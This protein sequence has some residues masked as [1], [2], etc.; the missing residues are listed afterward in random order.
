MELIVH[1]EL[2]AWR[3]TSIEESGVHIDLLLYRDQRHLWFTECGMLSRCDHCA[4][5]STTG[6]TASAT[7]VKATPMTRRL[8][9][10]SLRWSDRAQE[11]GKGILEAGRSSAPR[12]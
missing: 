2:H 10:P 9:V 6:A 4:H 1:V 12:G 8:I 7:S 3:A 5:S 11:L